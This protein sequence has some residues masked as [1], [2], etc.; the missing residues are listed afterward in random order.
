MALALAGCSLNDEVTPQVDAGPLPAAAVDDSVTIAEGGI[1]AILVLANDQGVALVVTAVT[2]GAN[3][4]VGIAGNGSSVRYTPNP[5]FS[6]S[7]S[8]TYTV[9]DGGGNADTATVN[10]T[11]TNIN[12]APF[13][14]AQAF[15]VAEGVSHTGTLVATDVDSATLTY[16]I[17][18]MPANGSLSITNATTGA[19]EYS[20]NGSETIA[21]S[22]TFKANDGSADSNTATV[23]ITVIAINDAPVITGQNA[24]ST[25]EEASRAIVFDDLLVTDVD[26]SYPTDFTLS[27]MDGANYSRSG[28]SI[29]PAQNFNGTLSVPVRVND[30]A[31]DSNTFNLSVTVTAVNDAPVITGQNAVTLAENTSRAIVLGDLLVTDVDNSYPADFTLSVMD[32]ANYSRSGNTI[33]PTPDFFGSLSVPVRVND[34]AA[35][36]NTFNLAVT[37]TEVLDSPWA[38]SLHAGVFDV[39][40]N[41]RRAE[42]SWPLQAG[43]DYAVCVTENPELSP[44]NFVADCDQYLDGLGDNPTQPFAVTG[45]SNGRS[46]YL[47]LLD[48]NQ[49]LMPIAWTAARP[50]T[51]GL[52]D[53]VDAQAIGAD[54]TR[55]V[56]G[57]FTEA[58]INTGGGV[59]LADNAAGAQHALAFP[60]IA[61]IVNAVVADGQ[62][63][64]FVGGS[65]I[66]AGGEPRANL[67]R[68]DRL[69]RLT[70][71]NAATNGDVH[72]LLL[73]SGV[74]YVGGSFTQ[75]GAVGST[76]TSRNRLAAFDAANGALMPAWDP[77]ADNTVRALAFHAGLVYAGGD[78]TLAGGG[79]SGS[80]PHNRL[81]AI[82]A[83]DGS[84]TAWAP[85]IGNNSVLAVAADATGVYAA[86]NFTQVNGAERAGLVSLALADGSTRAEFGTQTVN[87]FTPVRTLAL[88]GSALYFG[89]SF[90]SI[91]VI[92]R[93][94]LAAVNTAD[95]SLL[96]WNPQAPGMLPQNQGV[97]ALTLA[98]G[99][100]YVAGS[101]TGGGQPPVPR[102]NLLAARLSD[103]QILDWNPGTT[104]AQAQAVAVSGNAVYAGGRFHAAGGGSAGRVARARLAAFDGTD[105]ALTAWD[106]GASFTVHALA[107][108][109]GSVYAGG[110]FTSVGAGTTGGTGGAGVSRAR[111]AAFSAVDGS[112]RMDWD[113]GANERILALAVDAGSVYAGGAFGFTQAGFGTTGGTGGAG[114]TRNRLA[115]FSAADGSLR[116]D[117]DPGANNMVNGFAIDGGFVYAV[118]SFSMA[119]GGGT[120]TTARGGGAAFSV[121]DASLRPD[122]NPASSGTIRD[123]EIAN[124]IVYLGGSFSI[125]K[126][127]SVT[128][129]GAVTLASSSFVSSWR[130]ALN[131]QVFSLALDGGFVYAGGIFTLA[132][133]SGPATTPRN[134]LAAFS[135]ANGSLRPDWDPGANDNV[136]ELDTDAGLIYAGGD[137]RGSNLGA[138]QGVASF[139]TADGTAPD[140]GR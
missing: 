11:V 17:V 113:P 25:A 50:D 62:G 45:L 87:R 34:G 121:A 100:A 3:G 101:F 32:G 124:G 60:A 82:D 69:G 13:A 67:A 51:W 28:N 7:D 21:D 43:A 125:L 36:S 47:A 88:D 26:N 29:T 81:A 85:D 66:S 54:G 114:A 97:F 72:A 119:G 98:D 4:A 108:D 19:F 61:G 68:V 130:P 22:F 127:N 44:S 132:G 120:G 18:G 76:T 6:G 103:G 123:I 131:S 117:W 59:V 70:G 136:L 73:V 23:S 137:F 126:G 128:N 77:G 90:G 35:D 75:A 39:A 115:A 10:V 104:S 91:G 42:L 37:V 48:E 53:R 30:G 83:G 16:S 46:V 49:G 135:I 71:W 122:W 55:Y 129:L 99:I 52:N 14:Q 1:A 109:G 80:S 24:V 139:T 138:R 140:D 93:F 116:M 56:G 89:G 2:Q 33:T 15:T 78:F 112:V 8:F 64:F 134:R 79:G 133:G 63:G 106:P 5:D 12:D 95:G 9:T 57:N 58:A 110:S 31:A 40:V 20:H 38:M 41:S 74:L 102:S 107:T 86:G 65:F 84:V 105:G 27:V 94:G 96:P 111:L 92:G 118:G